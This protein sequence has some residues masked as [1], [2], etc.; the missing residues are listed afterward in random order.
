MT[1]TRDQG[2]I[3]E[4][5]RPRG[6]TNVTQCVTIQATLAETG[7]SNP[8]G[9]GRSMSPLPAFPSKESHMA[10]VRYAPFKR[11][12]RSTSPLGDFLG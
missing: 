4:N 10:I 5:S 3:I 12:A 9:G 8:P 1:G 6:L 2:K 7:E 11:P